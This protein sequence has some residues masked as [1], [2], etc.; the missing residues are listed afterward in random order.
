MTTNIPAARK[1][2][3]EALN[4]AHS[5]DAVIR[6]IEIALTMMTRERTKRITAP[7]EGRTITPELEEQIWRTYQQHPN[8]STMSIAGQHDVNPGRVSEVIA[9][10]SA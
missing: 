10:R 2:L 4:E 5:R 8:W 6:L 7:R 3:H 1:I 9:R